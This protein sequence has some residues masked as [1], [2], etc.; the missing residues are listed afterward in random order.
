MKRIIAF[1]LGGLV[2]A[3]AVSI[4]AAE[5]SDASASSLQIPATDEGLPGQGEIR[6]YEWFQNL[7]LQR[8]TQWAKD[9]QKDQ[10]ALVFLGDSITQYWGDVPSYFPGIK[11]ANR[12]ISGDTTRGVLIRLQDVIALN[13]RGVVL[14]IGTNDLDEF[15]APEKAAGNVKLILDALKAHNP[16][17]PVILCEVMPS[18]ETR[19]RPAAQIKKLNQLY[20]DLVKDEPQVTVLDTWSLFATP[21]GDAPA[22]IFPDLLHPKTV[23]YAKWAAALRPILETVGLSPAWPDDFKPEEGFESLFNGRDLSGWHYEGQPA[24]DG[25]TA[26]ADGRYVAAN[27]RLVVTVSR[28]Q[29]DYKTLWTTRTFP[30][31]FVLRLE[32]RASPN[33]DSGIFIREPQLQCRDYGIAGPFANLKH[34]RPLDWNEIIVTVK[35]GLA[36]ATCNG[37]VLIDAMPVPADGPIG[38]ES[39][40]G[41]VEYRRIRVMELK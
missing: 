11:V 12:G 20:L 16:K 23:G 26:S 29:R 37:E 41:Q 8:R 25:A 30:K 2:A 4:Q 13:P 24:L 40:H 9:V 32:F 22:E 39:D 3:A 5:S 31:D 38:L 7:W 17:M 14:L 36:H 21:T 33:A 6:R 35:G 34:Y 10:G 1:L 28:T 19:H 27:Q 18:S 15:T